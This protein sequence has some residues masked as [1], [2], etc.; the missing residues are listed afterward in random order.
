MRNDSNMKT[1]FQ[2]GWKELNEYQW[3]AVTD[4]SPACVV[5]ASVGSGKTTVLTAKVFYLHSEKQIPL[6]HMAVLTFT[7]KAAGE[8]TE[9]LRA[10]ESL[11]TE[12]QLRGFGTFHSVALRLLKEQLPVERAGWTRD[13]TV[14]DPDEETDLALDIIAEKGL[15]IKYKNRLKKR[16]EQEYKAYLGGAGE[17][18]YKDDLYLLYPLLEEEKKKQDKMTFADLLQVSTRLLREEKENNDGGEEKKAPVIPEWIIVDEVQDSDAMQ[19]D[20]LEALKG[21]ETKLFAVGDPNQVIYSWRGTGDNMFFLLKHRFGAKE[22]TL[23][24]NYRSSAVILEAANRFLQFGT[25]IEGCRGEGNLITVKNHYDPFQEAEYLAETIRELHETGGSGESGEMGA[26]GKLDYGQIA[27]LYRLQSQAEIL[28]KVF[29]RAQI[30]YE[31]SVK[32]TLKDIPVLDWMVKVLRF[33]VNPADEQTGVSVLTDPRFGEKYTKKKAR[34]IIR[35]KKKEETGTSVG[36]WIRKEECGCYVCSRIDDTY[37]R[38]LDTFLY[39]VKHEKD[40]LTNCRFLGM[41]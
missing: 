23:P 32:R 8:I 3:Q 30:P 2:D 36:N 13:F 38:V 12:E 21:P 31:L 26:R 17:S 25:R 22:L 29:E 27:V 33:S 10:K 14:M 41:Q 24:V 7:N 20:F 39:Q 15:K 18:R 5:N 28:E 4:E 6:E 34:E 19:M 9:R 11:L 16:L 37:R 40:F 35:W 1:D